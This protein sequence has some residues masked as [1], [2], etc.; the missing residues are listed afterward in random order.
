M[1]EAAALAIIA[2]TCDTTDPAKE[3][4]HLRFSAEILP[5]MEELEVELARRLLALNYTSPDLEVTIARFRTSAELF[6]E[7]NVPLSAE[8][9]EHSARYQKITGGLTVM[10]DGVE[11]TLPELQPYLQATDRSIRERAFRQS[12]GAYAGLRTEL[13]DIFDTL[14][15]LRVRMAR[16]AGFNDYEAYAFGPSAGSITP[17][18][19]VAD[20]TRPSRRWSR[21]RSSAS[22]HAGSGNWG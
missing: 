14:F 8:I 9:E 21:P 5:K 3:S 18:R 4:A 1:T 17:P 12:C 10:W 20:S 11:T 2:Y 13:A 7:E 16:N 22:W 6:R 15:D 19:T